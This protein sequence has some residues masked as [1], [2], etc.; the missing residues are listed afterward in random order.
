MPCFAD[1]RSVTNASGAGA[2]NN[3]RKTVARSLWPQR[4][5]HPGR[6]IGDSQFRTI[7]DHRILLVRAD[8]IVVTQ[9][10]AE[11]VLRA[12]SRR[13]SQDAPGDSGLDHVVTPRSE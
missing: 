5:R 13:D 3:G 9:R 4:D 6:R 2:I 7:A 1:E 10:Q 12:R 8:V 11:T